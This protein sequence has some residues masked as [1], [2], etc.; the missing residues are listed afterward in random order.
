MAGLYL[1]INFTIRDSLDSTLAMSSDIFFGLS[2]FNFVHWSGNVVFNLTILLTHVSK[3]LGVAPLC[4]DKAQ[5]FTEKQVSDT[6]HR[7][8]HTKAT[9]RP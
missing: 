4:G 2:V 7:A 8:F 3:C 5:S 9:K 1:E 6:S